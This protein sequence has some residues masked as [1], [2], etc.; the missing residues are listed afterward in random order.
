MLGA[1]G[2]VGAGGGPATAGGLQRQQQRRGDR[3]P[4]I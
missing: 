2:P 4:A 3:E 1:A